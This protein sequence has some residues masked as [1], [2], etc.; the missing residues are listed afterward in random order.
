[1]FFLEKI[2]TPSSRLQATTS[3]RFV[4]TTVLLY[5]SPP[6]QKIPIKLTDSNLTLHSFNRCFDTSQPLAG[7]RNLPH[8]DL[9]RC[10]DTSQPLAGSRNLPHTDLACHLIRARQ[11]T[12]VY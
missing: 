11:P 4:K 3:S 12:L 9:D 10:F 8:T 6:P 7:S 2:T 5:A 1:M